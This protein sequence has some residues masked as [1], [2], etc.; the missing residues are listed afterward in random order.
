MALPKFEALY[1]VKP[2]VL[3]PQV[4]IGLSL[5][6]SG[7]GTVGPLQSPSTAFIIDKGTGGQSAG[8]PTLGS[9]VDPGVDPSGSYN[10]VLQIGAPVVTSAPLIKPLLSVYNPA[11]AGFARIGFGCPP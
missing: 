8:N 1:S 9:V 10:W 5:G 3:V 2:F 4:T 6:P 11:P 7:L